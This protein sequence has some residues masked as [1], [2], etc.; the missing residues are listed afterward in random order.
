MKFQR[1]GF[2]HS[3]VHL[4]F[5]KLLPRHQHEN[6]KGM[7]AF[8]LTFSSCD[9]KASQFLQEKKGFVFLKNSRAQLLA[10]NHPLLA[11]YSLKGEQC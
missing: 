5:N 4:S 10:N 11:I 8:F 3:E 2:P 1:T 9:F 7:N 6:E